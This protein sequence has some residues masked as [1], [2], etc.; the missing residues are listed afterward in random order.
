M[1]LTAFNTELLIGLA[2]LDTGFSRAVHFVNVMV[3]DFG[4]HLFK[5]YH[6]CIGGSDHSLTFQGLDS[7]GD[8]HATSDNGDSVKA[9]PFLILNIY[10]QDITMEL[11]IFFDADVFTFLHGIEDRHSLVAHTI[12]SSTV[13]SVAAIEELVKVGA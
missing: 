12:V 10:L 9:K 3:D 1:G 7:R 4:Y 13:G 8:E 11:L 5:S 2:A 6:G